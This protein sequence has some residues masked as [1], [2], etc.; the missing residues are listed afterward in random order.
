MQ[1]IVGGIIEKDNKFLLVQEKEEESFE[2]WAIPAGK[3]EVNESI[4]DGA[5]REIKEESGC[6]V[7]A[8]GIVYIGNKV[9]KDNIFLVIIF[10]TKLI[11]QTDNWKKDE[12]SDVQWFNYDDIMNNM[13][14]KL[15]KRAIKSAL[16]NFKENKIVPLDIIEI[17]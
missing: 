1:I 7:K 13:D 10:S 9:I 17:F 11:K 2:K 15:R 12:I 4:I 14:D 5:L 16:K 3:L 6:D 8:T